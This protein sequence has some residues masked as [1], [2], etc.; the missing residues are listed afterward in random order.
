MILC[1]VTTHILKFYF[2]IFQSDSVDLFSFNFLKS[3]SAF[4]RI[5]CR[6]VSDWAGMQKIASHQE[7][8]FFFFCVSRVDFLIPIHVREN[9]R[10]SQNIPIVK[11]LALLSFKLNHLAKRFSIANTHTHV[12]SLNRKDFFFFLIWSNFEK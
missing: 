1:Q 11:L 8:N 9:P 10:I 6:I 5:H 3:I 12:L 7:K 4:C 2:H